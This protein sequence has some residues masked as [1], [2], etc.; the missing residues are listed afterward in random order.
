[1]W[2]ADAPVKRHS[3]FATRPAG[4]TEGFGST[5]E[6]KLHMMLAAA[7]AEV[8]A[9][10]LHSLVTSLC[11]RAISLI[12]RAGLPGSLPG[13]PRH[14]HGHLPQWPVLEACAPTVQHELDS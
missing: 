12:L 4:P 7:E 2:P 13:G 11:C 3:A 14:A 9:Q 5:P 6:I 1:M 8:S 10:S